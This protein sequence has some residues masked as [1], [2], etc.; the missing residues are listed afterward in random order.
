MQRSCTVESG[1]NWQNAAS[2]YKQNRQTQTANFCKNPVFMWAKY[3]PSPTEIRN[4]PPGSE[5]ILS[6]HIHSRNKMSKNIG[7]NSTSKNEQSRQTQTAN[8]CKTL[9][10]KET[11]FRLSSTKFRNRSPGSKLLITLLTLAETKCQKTLAETRP[12]NISRIAKPKTVIF[13]KS[14]V[15]K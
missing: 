5:P 3:G 15:F 6:L 10:F 9:V 2:K 14:L 1:A 12:P 11:K 13:C 7:R 4:R 8:F